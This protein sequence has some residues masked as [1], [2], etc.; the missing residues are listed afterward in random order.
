[1]GS[2]REAPKSVFILTLK[3]FFPAHRTQQC[4]GEGEYSMLPARKIS[5][6]TA[7]AQ[8]LPFRSV[9]VVVVN[10]VRKLP[11]SARQFS[12]SNLDK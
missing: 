5:V 12:T 8:I 4:S 2:G 9:T 11:P 1:M 7:A 3:R 10:F 6:Y